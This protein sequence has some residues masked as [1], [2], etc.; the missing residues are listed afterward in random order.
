[1]GDGLLKLTLLPTLPFFC[2]LALLATGGC[3]KDVRSISTYDLFQSAYYERT[4][5]FGC[6]P[7]T[8]PGGYVVPWIA[9]QETLLNARFDRL[10]ELLSPSDAE[11][12]D[13]AMLDDVMER[14]QL[15]YTGAPCDLEA[16]TRARFR[17]KQILSQ[18]EKR[19]QLQ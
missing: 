7:A 11:H 16:A 19:F 15:D 9:S 3:A 17:Y 18:L 10:R 1:M 13:K 4:T 14:G 6:L 12:L 2:L 5:G 8:K